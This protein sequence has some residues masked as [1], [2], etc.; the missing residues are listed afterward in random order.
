MRT[1]EQELEFQVK[2]IFNEFYEEKMNSVT[3]FILD[4]KEI[5]GMLSVK[6]KES[7]NG[8]FYH[9]NLNDDIFYK[10][11]RRKEQLILIFMKLE[12]F[13]NVGGASWEQ[14]L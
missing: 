6:I 1:R 2:D 5:D 11:I 8:N 13:I 10:F 7:D 3:S 9:D 14:R 12:S 4:E